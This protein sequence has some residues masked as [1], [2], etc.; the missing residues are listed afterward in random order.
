[1]S[2]QIYGRPFFEVISYP[3]RE[4][5]TQGLEPISK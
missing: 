1:M 5:N 2:R 4:L 3:A